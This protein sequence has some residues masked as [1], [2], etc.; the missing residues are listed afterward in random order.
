MKKTILTTLAACLCMYAATAQTLKDAIRMTES[1]RYEAASAAFKQLLKGG[2]DQGGDVWFY[3]GDNFF[4]WDVLDSAKM[5]FQKGADTKPSNPLN[6]TGLGSIA[7]LEHNPDL[8][9]QNFYKASSLTTTQAKELSKGKQVQVY[10]NIAQAYLAGTPKNLPDAFLNINAAMKVDPKNPEVYLL[11]G[12][13]WVEKNITDVSE[14]I[15]NYEKASELDKTLAKPHMKLGQMWMRVQN[16]EEG[17][18]EFNKA[19]EMDATFAPAYRARGDLYFGSGKPKQAIEDYQKYLSMNNSAT[20]KDKYAKSLFQIK[21]YK[22][23]IEEIKQAQ[24]KDSSSVSL[25]RLRG[26]SY[27]ETGD[28]VQ[29][30]RDIVNY[31]DKMKKKNKNLIYED[32]SYY[33]KLL[34]KTGQDSLGILQ[35]NKAIAMDS[36]RTDAYGDVA[37]I[38]YNSKRYPQAA[39]YYKLKIKMS[40]KVNILDYNSLGQAYYKDKQ[41]GKADTAF[42]MLAGDPSYEVFGNSWRGKCNF[43]MENQEKPE[44]KA[45]PY[46]ELVI[47]KGSKDVERNK[48][49]LISAY[50]Y[51]GFY[52]F[53][54]KNYDGAKAAFMKVQELD[55]TNEKAKSG[56]EDKD[57]KKAAGTFELVKP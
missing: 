15:K 28:Y 52:Y 10:L 47:Q 17:L 4:E 41:Y 3:Y 39:K 25:L 48:K 20:A 18:K 34:I 31:M 19:I 21:D 1:E 22:G 11:M 2:D 24:M 38:Y 54:Q 27:Y 26:Y 5:M 30:L 36:S 14:A 55:P 23:A 32:Y 43:M 29:G 12:D 35:I 40:K 42:I 57:I 7:W 33:G 37:T 13:Y 56:L 16:W 9:K 49:D 51:L 46:Y 6:F 45:K 50:S 44:G 8:A 53:V